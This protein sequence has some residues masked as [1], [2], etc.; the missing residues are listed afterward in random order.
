MLDGGDKVSNQSCRVILLHPLGSS[1]AAASA[2][3]AWRLVPGRLLRRLLRD[4][5]KPRNEPVEGSSPEDGP[6]TRTSA[7]A[8]SAAGHIPAMLLLFSGVESLRPLA[9]GM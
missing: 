4:C 2:G 3:R 7:A 6:S 8:A 5:N 9:A 1:S